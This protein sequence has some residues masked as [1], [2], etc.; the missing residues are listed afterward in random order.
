MVGVWR[1]LERL[2]SAPYADKILDITKEE[3][4]T[5][6]AQVRARWRRQRNI[7]EPL[8]QELGMTRWNAYSVFNQITSAARDVNWFLSRQLERIGGR[9]IEVASSRAA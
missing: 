9:L 8:R 6:V 1:V 3:R 2:V 4:K 7:L 5:L